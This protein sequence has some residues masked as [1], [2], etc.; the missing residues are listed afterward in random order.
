MGVFYFVN[1]GITLLFV[2]GRYVTGLPER[3]ASTPLSLR[4]VWLLPSPPFHIAD[5]SSEKTTF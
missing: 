5:A 1:L 4:R 3:S 2:T